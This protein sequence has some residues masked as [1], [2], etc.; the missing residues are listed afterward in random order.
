ME[1][2]GNRLDFEVENPDLILQFSW[3]HGVSLQFW[4][5]DSLEGE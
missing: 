5:S 2:K 4:E 3:M 1:M